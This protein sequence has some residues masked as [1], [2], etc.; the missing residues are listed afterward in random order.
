MKTRLLTL[1]FMLCMSIGLAQNS[2]SGNVVDEK[3]KQPI[4]GVTILIKDSTKGTT[5]D[6]DGNYSIDASPAD[7]LVVSYLG[8]LTQ[9][10]KINDKLTFSILLKEDTSELDEV[11]V[12][13]YG[14]KSKI[15]LTSAVST[16]DEETLKR[17]PVA[18]VSNGLEG[19][20]S[21]LFV[22]QNSGEPGFSN[23]SFEVRNFGNALVIVDGAPG[24][25]NQ[26]E[27]NEIESIS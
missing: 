12:V 22:R 9:E 15:K 4:P 18:A 23:S 16:I 8:Y 1:G 11:I 26:L 7:I 19:L 2:V 6:F 5:T 13:G 21:G 14:T 25:L 3:T 10:I 20:A 27:A 24:D 17:L